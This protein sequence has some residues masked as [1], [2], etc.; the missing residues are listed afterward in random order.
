MKKRHGMAPIDFS[1]QPFARCSRQR[2]RPRT[3]PAELLAWG[4]VPPGTPPAATAP[5]PA[6]TP[7]EIPV[8]AA[9]AVIPLEDPV[10][11]DAVLLGVGAEEAN[12]GP[13]V[14]NLM[15]TSSPVARSLAR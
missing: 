9:A 3:L 2:C 8:A 11:V 7:G 13:R 12:R 14:L 15:A 1:G 6:A 10:A 4:G 5:V